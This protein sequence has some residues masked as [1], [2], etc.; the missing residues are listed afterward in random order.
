M[1]EGTWREGLSMHI[2]NM[3]TDTKILAE[4][5]RRAEKLV[6]RTVAAISND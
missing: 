6:A 3:A 2:R 5:G 1:E 4:L